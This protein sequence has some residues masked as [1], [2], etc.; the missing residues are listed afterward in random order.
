ML[1]FVLLTELS[2]LGLANPRGKTY[3]LVKS[4]GPLDESVCTISTRERWEG[5]TKNRDC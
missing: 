5:D 4:L 2:D 1:N 3:A